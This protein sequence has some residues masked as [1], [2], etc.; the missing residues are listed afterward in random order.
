MECQPDST[1]RVVSTFVI[2]FY[3]LNFVLNPFLYCITNINFMKFVIK[4]I[5]RTCN[6]KL[7]AALWSK[8]NADLDIST[9]VS[10]IDHGLERSNSNNCSPTG[11]QAE[12]IYSNTLTVP[13][14]AARKKLS[15]RSG[16]SGNETPQGSYVQELEG[17]TGNKIFITLCESNGGSKDCSEPDNIIKCDKVAYTKTAKKK[18]SSSMWSGKFR[19]KIDKCSK[20]S[21]QGKNVENASPGVTLATADQ[22]IS[23]QNSNQI[24]IVGSSLD[25]QEI[26]V[27]KALLYLTTDEKFITTFPAHSHLFEIITNTLFT[28]YCDYYLLYHS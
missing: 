25:G 22:K 7:C 28:F 9:N 14:S 4:L 8:I 18:N 26:W 6:D 1:L 23:P 5:K 19:D 15:S 3:L 10:T 12:K 20:K 2:N 16:N 13:D 27:L 21:K 17:S 24:Q 11:D